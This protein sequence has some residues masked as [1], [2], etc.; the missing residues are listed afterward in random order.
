MLAV[1][2]AGTTDVLSA[3]SDGPMSFCTLCANY[4][5]SSVKCAERCGSAERASLRLSG[6]TRTVTPV[7]VTSRPATTSRSVDILLRAIQAV[8]GAPRT[9]AGGT[10]VAVG[11]RYY[12]GYLPC[13]TSFQTRTLQDT[14]P[15]RTFFLSLWELGVSL[16]HL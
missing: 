14:L 4:T 2:H 13:T 7:T 12:L 8:A 3:P 16:S 15:A 9:E 10:P 11:E 5:Q 6:T 1:Q